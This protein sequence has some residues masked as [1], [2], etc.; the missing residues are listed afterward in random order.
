MKGKEEEPTIKC[1]SLEAL[2]VFLE[3]CEYPVVTLTEVY[4]LPILT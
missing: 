4:L 2:R 1:R 3:T